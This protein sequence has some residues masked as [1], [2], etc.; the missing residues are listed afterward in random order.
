MTHSLIYT[1]F[2]NFIVTNSTCTGT[3]LTPVVGWMS[4]GVEESTLIGALLPDLDQFRGD[5][6]QTRG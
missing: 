3:Y 6:T 4:A 1:E 2:I 5:P